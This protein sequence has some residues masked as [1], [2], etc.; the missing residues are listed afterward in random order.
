MLPIARTLN[1]VLFGSILLML[2]IAVAGT[3]DSDNPY[4]TTQA[5]PAFSVPKPAP[6]PRHRLVRHRCPTERSCVANF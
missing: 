1:A 2:P 5:T 4:V 6:V 3:P